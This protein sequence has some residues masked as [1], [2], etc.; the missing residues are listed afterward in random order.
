MISFFIVL[1]LEF[2]YRYNTERPVRAVSV[3]IVNGVPQPL[4]GVFT[5]RSLLMSLTIMFTTVC[6]IIR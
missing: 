6:L 4:R 2:F 5:T 3:E 1:G